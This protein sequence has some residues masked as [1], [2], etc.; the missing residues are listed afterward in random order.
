LISNTLLEFDSQKSELLEL[1]SR[2]VNAL[3]VSN[4]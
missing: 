1:N 3:S 2:A 4:D